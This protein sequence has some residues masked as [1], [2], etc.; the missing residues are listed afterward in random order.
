MVRKQLYIDDR[1]DGILKQ[2]AAKT[3]LTE[4]ALVR[5]ALEKVYDEDA[6]RARRVAH[7]DEFLAISDEIA[8]A[9][10]DSGEEVIITKEDYRGER[11]K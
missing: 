8:Q 2:E 4:S 3:G 7:W 10:I 9:I 5:Q 6:E 1:M 11:Y